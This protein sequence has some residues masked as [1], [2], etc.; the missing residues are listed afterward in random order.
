[1]TNQIE[2]LGLTAPAA[3]FMGPSIVHQW[4]GEYLVSAGM[5]QA[6]EH[7]LASFYRDRVFDFDPESGF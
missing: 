4:E 2:E 6:S 5:I 1:M 7:A 3:P